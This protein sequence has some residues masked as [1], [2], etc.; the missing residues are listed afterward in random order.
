MVV[1]LTFGQYL[2]GTAQQ[3]LVRWFTDDVYLKVH[4]NIAELEW[5]VPCQ[6]N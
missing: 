2:K 5:Y 6:P 4:S 1:D 3:Y